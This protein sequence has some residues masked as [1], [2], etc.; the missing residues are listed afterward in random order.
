MSSF[1]N[2]MFLIEKHQVMSRTRR[3]INHQWLVVISAR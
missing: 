2:V 3:T 1:S